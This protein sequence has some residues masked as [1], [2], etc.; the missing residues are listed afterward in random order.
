MENFMT[1]E[2]EKKI[3]A[4]FRNYKRNKKELSEHYN[5]PVPSGIAYDKIKVMT[6]KSRNGQEEMTLEYIIKR[7]DLFKKVYIVDEVLNWFRLEG[8]GRDRF[9]KVFMIGGCSW[10]KAEMELHIS[11]QT[12]LRWRRDVLEKA[13]MVASWLKIF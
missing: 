1:K 6:D 10:I 3:V 2:R 4:L 13:E 9:I 7:E 8:H 5:I 12:I 11:N